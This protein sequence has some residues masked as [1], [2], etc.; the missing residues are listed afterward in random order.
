MVP[1]VARPLHDHP[2]FW[3]TAITLLVLCSLAAYGWGLSDL[4]RAPGLARSISDAAFSAIAGI[5]CLLTLYGTLVEPRRL[6]VNKKYVHIGLSA[7]LRIVLASDFHIGPYKRER[8][9]E[10]LIYSINN[11]R[12]DLI[13]LPGDF[14]EGERSD[15]TPLDRLGELRARHGVFAVTGNHDAGHFLTL[16][17]VPYQTIDRTDELAARLTKLGIHFLRNEHRIIEHGGQRIAIAGVDDTFMRS[18]DVDAALRGIPPDTP[19]ILL[20]HNPDIIAHPISRQAHLIVS[21]HTHGGQIRLPVI[22][23]LT[24]IPNRLG[25]RYA[26]GLF[27]LAQHSHLLVTSGAGET[28]ARARLFCPPEIVEVTVR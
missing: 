9:I 13:L 27:C 4:S 2:L 10:Q 11:L 24:P 22:G 12:P 17:R 15:I 6:V 18:C 25:R 3:D 5:G 21:G 1:R 19:T 16:R 8:F 14:L 23:P 26:K 7:P 20:S 28:W